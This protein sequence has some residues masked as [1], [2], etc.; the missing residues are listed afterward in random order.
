ML[1]STH[2]RVQWVLPF[3]LFPTLSI[4]ALFC[5]I[6]TP[7]FDT[8]NYVG[9]VSALVALHVEGQRENQFWP[10]RWRPVGADGE[11]GGRY[12]GRTWSGRE[13]LVTC[14]TQAPCLSSGISSSFPHVLIV[15]VARWAVS[16][17]FSCIVSSISVCCLTV[18]SYTL[19]FP[20]TTVYLHNC[21]PR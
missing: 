20:F 10:F 5:P 3:L 7:Q 19:L 21:V 13:Y 8:P 12:C 18:S 6:A 15:Y 4:Q 1:D 16:I 11:A 14:K 17:K 9:C 2:D